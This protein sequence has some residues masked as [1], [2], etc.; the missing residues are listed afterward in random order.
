LCCKKRTK[1]TVNGPIEAVFKLLS[2]EL[3]DVINGLPEHLQ[4]SVPEQLRGNQQAS[5]GSTDPK[6]STPP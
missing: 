2:E 6:G 5:E 1:G 3:R 4:K